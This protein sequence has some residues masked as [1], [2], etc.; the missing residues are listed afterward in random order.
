M[1]SISD[2]TGS[3]PDMYGLA[4]SIIEDLGPEKGLSYNLCTFQI[5]L[6]EDKEQQETKQQSSAAISSMAA[7]P[8]RSAA[9]QPKSDGAVNPEKVY[10]QQGP[11]IFRVKSGTHG[12][13]GGIRSVLEFGIEQVFA[14]DKM[15]GVVC[16]RTIEDFTDFSNSLTLDITAVEANLPPRTALLIIKGLINPGG[17]GFAHLTGAVLIRP[18]FRNASTPTLVC[19]PVF[20]RQAPP[21]GKGKG[22]AGQV[23]ET[24]IA[25]GLLEVSMYRAPAFSD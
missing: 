11:V 10:N 19:E 6:S 1:T 13:A 24:T 12:E 22:L 17:L 21:R 20:F 25:G 2:I 3:L 18:Q 8:S 9:S 15:T 14:G 4:R 7:S 16:L 23:I 5:N